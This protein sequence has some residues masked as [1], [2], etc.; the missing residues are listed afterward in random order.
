MKLFE[1]IAEYHAF[2]RKYEMMGQLEEEVPQRSESEHIAYMLEFNEFVKSVQE[3]LPEYGTIV[4]LALQERVQ[5]QQLL[6]K[7]GKHKNDLS[8]KS[9]NRF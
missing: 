3:K 1:N 9:A 6:S 8:T 5:R 2:K 4:E 7:L